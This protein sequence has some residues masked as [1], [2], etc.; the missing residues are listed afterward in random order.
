[1]KTPTEL[2][3]LGADFALMKE[4][5][6]HEPEALAR[7][8]SRYHE[9]L[10]YT[11]MQIVH[12]DADADEVVQDVFTQ[13]WTR[14]ETYCAAKGK[15]LCWMLTLSRRRAIDC[16]RRRNT[17]RRA[18]ERFEVV[19]RMPHRQAQKELSTDRLVSREDLR[20]YLVS[21]MAELPPAQQVVLEKGFFGHM[22]QRQIAAAM[23]A[24]LGTIKTRMELGL[25]KLAQ[26][27]M[28][29][30]EMVE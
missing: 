1:M 25:R 28:P 13:L 9:L 6:R 22:S 27:A 24:P 5:A 7:L 26:L 21:L 14:P 23:G 17:Y 10:H 11:A 16:V 18:S 19:N 12:D 2:D 3:G 29:C 8:H 15:P 4:I 30:R 20:A